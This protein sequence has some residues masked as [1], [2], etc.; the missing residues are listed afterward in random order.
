MPRFTIF[1]AG[2]ALAMMTLFFTSA[3]LFAQQ[4]GDAPVVRAALPSGATAKVGDASEI[5]NRVTGTLASLHRNLLPGD[6]RGT[7][8]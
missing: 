8:V 1:T 2:A 3:D 7:Q 4:S 5:T 6:D